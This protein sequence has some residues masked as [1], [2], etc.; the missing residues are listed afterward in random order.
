MYPP[1]ALRA[2]KRER[3]A[4]IQMRYMANGTTDWGPGSPLP[5]RVGSLPQGP[6]I[7]EWV[8]S[9]ASP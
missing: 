6:F 8:I 3:P 2:F 7:T 4:V 5:Q 9:Q 1:G